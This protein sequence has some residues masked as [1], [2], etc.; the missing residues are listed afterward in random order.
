MPITND[1]FLKVQGAIT[2]IIS[3]GVG[4]AICTVCKD[5]GLDPNKLQPQQLPDLKKGM[6]VHYSK[7]WAQKITQVESALDSVK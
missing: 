2:P 3:T 6:V 4:S 5:M 1:V 7:Y